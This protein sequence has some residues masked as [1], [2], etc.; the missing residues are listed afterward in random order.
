MDCDALAM[1]VYSD[2]LGT[3]LAVAGVPIG[4]RYE[5]KCWPKSSGLGPNNDGTRHAA[6]ACICFEIDLV[7]ADKNNHDNF[8]SIGSALI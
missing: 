4:R 8:K 2:M 5:N 6:S 7:S 1:Q 3:R